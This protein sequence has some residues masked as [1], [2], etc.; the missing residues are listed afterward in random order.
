MIGQYHQTPLPECV[1]TQGAT[2]G[3]AKSSTEVLKAAAFPSSLH[4]ELCE[5]EP[6]AGRT[7]RL[8]PSAEGLSCIMKSH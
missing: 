1:L 3:R 8:E 7:A 5:N 4:R 6:Q 2:E